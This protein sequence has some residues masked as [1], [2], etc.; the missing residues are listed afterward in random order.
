MPRPESADIGWLEQMKA[1]S[2]ALGQVGEL[3][4][5][6]LQR[7]LQSALKEEDERARS[8]HRPLLSTRSLSRTQVPTTHLFAHLDQ[9]DSMVSNE[10]Q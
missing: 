8:D 4:I 10:S 1:R 7:D 6:S 5:S 3:A 9:C 2:P